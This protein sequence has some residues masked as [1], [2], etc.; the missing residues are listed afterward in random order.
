MTRRTG[1]AGSAGQRVPN[2]FESTEDVGTEG[3]PPIPGAPSVFP[4][5][6]FVI[7]DRSATVRA[8]GHALTSRGWVREEQGNG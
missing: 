4:V 6:R 7:E 8:H 5:R 2:P 3:A 1:K